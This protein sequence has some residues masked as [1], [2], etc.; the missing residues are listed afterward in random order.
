[1]QWSGWSYKVYIGY[2]CY[3]VQQ[4]VNV[5]WAPNQSRK[6]W[7][8]CT[9]RL[10]SSNHSLNHICCCFCQEEGLPSEMRI[11]QQYRYS[12]QNHPSCYS[13]H[14][15]DGLVPCISPQLPPSESKFHPRRKNITSST[16]VVRDLWN[17]THISKLSSL[18]LWILFLA[19]IFWK[20]YKRRH[21][22]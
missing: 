10:T 22:E 18:T 20:I 11:C 17:A 19:A 6:Q 3:S 9:D 7:R 15:Q 16:L 4:G 8:G 1:M 14:S 12:P 13:P 5:F 21:A 2:T